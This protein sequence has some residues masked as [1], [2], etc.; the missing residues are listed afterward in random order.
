M[1]SG[2]KWNIRFGYA[3]SSLERTKPPASKW[4]VAPGPERRNSH[5]AP[6][7]GRF[8]FFSDGCSETGCVH[9]CWT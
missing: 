1:A 8:H 9:A 4:F 7:N 3:T 2:R 6:M 5:S